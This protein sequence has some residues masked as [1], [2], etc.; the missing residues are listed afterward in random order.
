MLTVIDMRAKLR[1]SKI[2]EFQGHYLRY[3][4]SK[5]NLTAKYVHTI[6]LERLV[7]TIDLKENV[8]LTVFNSGAIQFVGTKNHYICVSVCT[9]LT[10]WT[11]IFFG[12]QVRGCRYIVAHRSRF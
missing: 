2:L 11:F 7:R 6:E 1:F 5:N 3:A 12:R 8:Y 9:I 10:S 4:A